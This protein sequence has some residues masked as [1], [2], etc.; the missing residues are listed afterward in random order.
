[1]KEM[2]IKLSPVVEHIKAEIK[3]ERK[4]GIDLGSIYEARYL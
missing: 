2:T 3:R 4:A 1:M